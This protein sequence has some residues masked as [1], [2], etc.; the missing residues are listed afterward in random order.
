[1]SSYKELLTYKK[2]L[3]G[4]ATIYD[5]NAWC[6]PRKWSGCPFKVKATDGV[7]ECTMPPQKD[8]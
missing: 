6:Y 2:L 5:A 3:Y 7:T 1:M 8:K 4:D